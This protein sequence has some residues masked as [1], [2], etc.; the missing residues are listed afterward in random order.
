VAST[1]GAYFVDQSERAPG[2]GSRV[3]I[4]DAELRAVTVVLELV[5]PAVALG[6]SLRETRKLKL[7]ERKP[8]AGAGRLGTHG[9]S[10]LGTIAANLYMIDRNRKPAR[11]DPRLCPTS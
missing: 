2:Q 8:A 1:I 6:R 4:L 7:D 10:E 11:Q 5:D 3:P 9:H